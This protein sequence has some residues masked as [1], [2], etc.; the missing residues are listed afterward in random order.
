MHR[1]I[2]KLTF[3]NTCDKAH[4]VNAVEY[5]NYLCAQHNAGID[6]MHLE[7]AMFCECDSE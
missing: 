5:H 4:Y 6:C 1:T 3:C 7:G 2:A